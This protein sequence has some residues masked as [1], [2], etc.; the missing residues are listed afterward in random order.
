MHRK[1]ETRRQGLLVGAVLLLVSVVASGCV[2]APDGYESERERAEAAG[3]PYTASFEDRVIPELPPAPSPHELLERAFLANGELEAAYFDWRAAVARVESAAGW[4]NTGLMPSFSY[5]F[6][7]E[8]LKSWDRTTVNVGFDASENLELPVKTRRRAKVALEAARA[9]GERFRAAKFSLQRKVLESWSELALVDERLRI[10]REDHGFLTL[11]ANTAPGRVQAGGPQR[12]LVA[13]VIAAQEAEDRVRSLEAESRALR[14]RLNGALGREPAAPLGTGD[15]LPASRPLPADDAAILAFGVDAN[16]ELAA[17]AREVAGREDALA[18]ARSMVL[19]DLVPFAGFTGGISQM[20]GF[21]AMLPT[22]IP[23]IRAEIAEAR[24]MSAGASA[25][26][27]QA[28]SDRGATF[29]AA[30]HVLRDSE[31]RADLFGRTILPAAR[32]LADTTRQGYEVGTVGLSDLVE[33]ER[34]LLEV[35]LVISE[36]RTE[37]ERRAAEIEELAGADLET[38][39]SRPDSGG[40]GGDGHGDE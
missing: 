17:L 4:P 8:S 31:R 18:L 33:A 11:L 5:M 34:L 23:E 22:A 29:V 25:V 14:V 32:L 30:L 38:L 36:A 40:E 7:G 3:V 27:R 6:S 39:A 35:R 16:P 2:L 21:A 26:A 12:E 37:R 15:E 20:V 9:A 28:R 1:R 19:P 10:A 13:V 24:A